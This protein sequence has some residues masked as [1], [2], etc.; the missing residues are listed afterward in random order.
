MCFYFIV[1][2]KNL[3]HNGCKECAL[4]VTR[5]FFLYCSL[6]NLFYCC[7]YFSCCYHSWWIKDCQRRL[8]EDSDSF[9][10][11]LRGQLCCVYAYR[12][13]RSPPRVAS[14]H[15]RAICLYL[16]LSMTPRP[17]RL[18]C[19]THPLSPI[20][21]RASV[22]CFFRAT[23]G[24]PCALAWRRC[25]TVEQITAGVYGDRVSGG[26]QIGPDVAWSRLHVTIVQQLSNIRLPYSARP[27][28]VIP[29]TMRVCSRRK[30][31]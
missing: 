24:L 25:R 19:H 16:L 8:C 1:L 2:Y 14:R 26:Q 20:C 3:E 11:Q 5:V 27:D 13:L 22:N 12:V 30:A 23:T 21:R 7:L 9:R 31:A 29:R 17:L 28:H 6:I 10:R 15:F 18:T 4:W